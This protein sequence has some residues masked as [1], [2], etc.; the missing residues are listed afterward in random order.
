M[1][2][3]K[4][5][6]K[7]TSACIGCQNLHRRCKHIEG[8][9]KCDRCLISDKPCAY[10]ARR[11]K[12]GPRSRRDIHENTQSILY[13]PNLEDFITDIESFAVPSGM[14]QGNTQSILYIPTLEDIIT[15][16][17]S[18]AVPSEMIQ[19]NTQSILY[20][21]NL[22]D[23]ITDIE[24]IAVPS[25]T[26]QE[27]TQ[28]ILYMPNLED[29]IIDIES[30]AAPSEIIQITDSESIQRG[31]QPRNR[32]KIHESVRLPTPLN[33]LLDKSNFYDIIDEIELCNAPTEADNEF[34]Q[35]FPENFISE[36]LAVTS[37]PC[38]QRQ[39]VEHVCHR[40][41]VIRPADEIVVDDRI[42]SM[43]HNKK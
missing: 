39:N 12:R 18:F 33:I 1:P 8:N 22:E 5:S 28:N 42:Y 43:N 15:N 37:T 27:N 23:F 10:S 7:A 31:P 26:I 11:K 17:E 32:R 9:E 6:K 2:K 41:C 30:S 20:I 36:L 16:I 34:L 38:P 40:G 24:S 25:K 21:P 14:I 3:D 19:G 4:K 29:I 35:C 13:M